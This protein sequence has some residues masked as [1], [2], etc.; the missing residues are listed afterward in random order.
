M[1]KDRLRAHPRSRG[2]NPYAASNDQDPKGSSPLTRGKRK[3]L[4]PPAD[5]VRL[6][7][8]HA[9][10]TLFLCPPGGEHGAHPRSR[11]E[12]AL[13]PDEVMNALGSSP[14]TR[15]KLLGADRALGGRGLIPA[16]AG[17]TRPR[18]H[19]DQGGG[20]HPRSRG[21]NFSRP[22]VTPLLPGSSPLT[23]GKPRLV[24]ADLPLGRLI[25]AHAG[26]TATSGEF[27]ERVKAHP[28]SRGENGRRACTWWCSLG[29]SPLTRGK[30]CGSPRPRTCRGLIPAH[31][32]K[33]S[34]DGYECGLRGAHPRSRGENWLLVALR[35][36][37]EGSSPLTRGKRGEG[38]QGGPL[39]GLIPAHAGKT[40]RLPHLAR[41][42]R[43]HPRSR[44]ENFTFGLSNRVVTG[45]SP[46]TRGKP[47]AGTANEPVGG[48][49]PAHAGKTP[50]GWRVR[51]SLRAHPRSRGENHC[52]LIVGL[53]I[54][55]SSPLTR[56]KL[57]HRRVGHNG[58]GLIPAHAGKTRFLPGCH[59][60]GRAHPR[61]RG[62][63]HLMPQ[64]M[65]PFEG[66]SPLT[67][68][69]RA[70]ALAGVSLP[71]L[72]PAHAGKTRRP[73]PRRR[74]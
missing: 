11:G 72:I 43:A 42:R 9:G 68:G 71:R 40:A 35:V 24:G 12:N 28:R 56:G 55:G 65:V 7:P 49:I 31:A 1:L 39:A 52:I 60:R 13:H 54:A 66:S 37:V 3:G 51:T 16:H 74:P 45:S 17:K 32:G 67:R 64:P 22:K 69:K 6:I 70:W 21:E 53:C 20:A 5:V 14:L 41:A 57:Q 26:K 15:G 58:G 27:V 2:E 34:F 30:P 4:T 33:T 46:L 48:L 25:P 62:E 38:E 47:V 44:G 23:R 8:A 36:G 59:G 73:R 63:N 18:N 50:A 29:S 61:S 19:Q 10:K